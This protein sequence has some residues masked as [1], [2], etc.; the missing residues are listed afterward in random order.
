MKINP[1][2]RIN[3][4]EGGFSLAELMIAVTIGLLILAGLSGVFSTTSKSRGEVE[5]ANRQIENGR[6]A[7]QL[8]TDDLK[9]AGYFGELNAGLLTAPAVMPDPCQ[10]SVADLRAAMALH[11]QGYDNGD[12]VPSCLSDVRSGTDIMVVRRASTCIA[13]TADC[14]AASV[15]RPYFQAS[16]CRPAAGTVPPELSS[17]SVLDHFAIDTTPASLGLHQRNCTDTAVIRRFVTH[18]YFVANNN[19][20]S[21]GIPT[22]KRA[23]LGGNEG[24]SDFK[25]VPLVEG[26]EDLQFEYGI[27][28]DAAGDPNGGS[29]NAYTADPGSFNACVAA[30]CVTNWHSVV[31]T[32]VHVLARNTEKT[33]GYTDAKTYTLGLNALGADHTLGPFN[34]AYKR[35]VY[36]SSVRLN[37]PAG[38]REP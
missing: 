29:P 3:S 11:V 36:Q 21:D 37:N 35:H 17:N 15:G 2:N 12:A 9:L 32:K 24:S 10:T 19:T 22:L 8:L 7:V 13:G 34:D 38:R 1:N 23:E 5:R 31:S 6:Y 26:I 30:A 25:I 14:D 28:T 27:D 20:P 18:I 4:K 16:L 33:T